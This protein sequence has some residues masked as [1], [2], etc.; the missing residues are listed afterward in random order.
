[1]KVTI[2][3]NGKKVDVELTA[4]QVK[5]LGL[6][7]EKKTGWERAN[8]DKA[9]TYIDSCMQLTQEMD[10][11]TLGDSMRYQ[12]GNYFTDSNLAVKMLKRVRLMLKMQR[13]ADKHN[14]P[15]DWNDSDIVKYR[16]TYNTEINELRVSHATIS[17]VIS[18]V[19]FSSYDIAEKAI[20]EFGDEI[21]DCYAESEVTR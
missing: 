8:S 19:Y 12:R 1:M 10:Y 18:A 6:Q 16:I 4:E 20:E 17:K 7:E 13:W 15:L 3:H 9:Y 2:E 14:E 11:E 21:M 5:E